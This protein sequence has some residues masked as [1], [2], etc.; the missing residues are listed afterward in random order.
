MESPEEGKAALWG[1][2][3][4]LRLKEGKVKSSAAHLTRPREPAQGDRLTPLK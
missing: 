4:A 2:E 1:P 3:K